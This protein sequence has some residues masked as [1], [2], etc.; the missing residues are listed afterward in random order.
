M[1]IAIIAERLAIKDG[2]RNWTLGQSD[3]LAIVKR[4]NY[5]LL[6]FRSTISDKGTFSIRIY[7]NDVT[8]PSHSGLDSLYPIVFSLYN[9]VARKNGLDDVTEQFDNI[10]QIQEVYPVGI[11]GIRVG[12]NATGTL[13]QWISGLWV[14]IFIPNKLGF[15]YQ[16]TLSTQYVASGGE[17]SVIISDLI[18]ATIIQITRETQPL[19]TADYTFDYTNGQINFTNPLTQYEKVFIIY[20]TRRNIPSPTPIPPIVDYEIINFVNES[21]PSI[22]NYNIDYVTYGQYPTVILVTY[23][24]FGVEEVNQATPKRN[25]IG[26]LLNSIVYNMGSPTTGFIILKR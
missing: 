26:G 11:E 10:A 6:D 22:I 3:L 18:N 23:D 24:E 7:P 19:A 25:L 2:T 13:W 17:S 5:I 1:E 8:I 4:T 21:S 16:N 14:D 15:Y 20:G 9:F 12:N